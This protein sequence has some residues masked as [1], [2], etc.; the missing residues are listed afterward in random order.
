MLPP[1]HR[2][3]KREREKENPPRSLLK[4]IRERKREKEREKEKGT[5]RAQGT[6]A[7]PFYPTPKLD[8]SSEEKYPA[9]AF[10]LFTKQ[11]TPVYMYTLPVRHLQIIVSS[12]FLSPCRGKEEEEE[13]VT[14]S[15]SSA[16]PG[17]HA[18]AFFVYS[19]APEAR[20]SRSNP[21]SDFISF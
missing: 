18:R 1:P 13:D 3:H 16:P 12:F 19:R 15:S 9:C 14:F 11:H 17:S 21:I 10:V 8:R 5:F 2:A 20:L 7:S 4:S 6:A